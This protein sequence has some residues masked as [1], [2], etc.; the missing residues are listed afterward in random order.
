MQPALSLRDR[1]TPAL[2]LL[3]ALSVAGYEPRQAA[4]LHIIVADRSFDDRQTL[5][6]KHYLMAAL[7]AR[8][9]YARGVDSFTST[10]S[11]TVYK[12]PLNFKKKPPR[13]GHARPNYAR[14]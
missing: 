1:R 6:N 7:A 14:C 8:E 12:H 5:G 9:L 10:E 11:N 13:G 4:Q 3:D 2:C